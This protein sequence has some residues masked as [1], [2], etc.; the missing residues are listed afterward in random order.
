[1][2]VTYGTN[3]RDFFRESHDGDII[4]GW[5]RNNPSGDEGPYNDHDQFYLSDSHDVA[6]YAGAGNDIVEVGDGS[7]IVFGG[8]GNDIITADILGFLPGVDTLDGGAGNDRISAGAGD[9]VINGGTGDDGID[10]FG[11]ASTIDAGDGNDG[12]SIGWLTEGTVRAGSGN[13][14]IH[15][16]GRLTSTRIDGGDGDDVLGLSAVDDISAHDISEVD[17]RSV[18]TLFT[19]GARVT[20]RP[21]QFNAFHL[22]AFDFEFSSFSVVFSEG[23]S[24]DFAPRSRGGPIKASGS[25]SDDGIAS[26][27]GDDEL[28][29]LAGNDVLNARGGDD[30]LQGGAGNDILIGGAGSDDLIGGLGNDKIDYSASSAAVSITLDGW[31]ASIGGDADGDRISGVENAVGSQFDDRIG[32]DARRNVLNGG[33]GNDTLLGDEG[34]DRLVGGTGRDV[35][36]YDSGGGVTVDLS[37]GVGRYGLA[38]GD[39]FVD[40]EDLQGGQGNDRFTGNAVDNSLWGFGGDDALTGLGG[41]DALDGGDGADRLSGGAGDDV[42]IGGRGADRLSGGGG[43]DLFRYLAV[44]DSIRAAADAIVAFDA[45]EGDQIDLTAID[46]CASTSVDDAFVFIG[47]A[48][49]SGTEGELRFSGGAVQAD[50]DGD[51]VADLFVRL[52]LGV[53]LSEETFLL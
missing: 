32:G 43:A 27:D 41:A 2:S 50:V 40:V 24:V 42:L 18:E 28:Y 29:G 25:M 44:T 12:I 46:A 34:A 5:G 6:I 22:I 26:G 10:D 3:R 13:D 1:M 45:A 15:I 35:V 53:V 21:D 14:W 8:N 48:G 33:A 4:Y 17:I 49:F 37:T 52:G 7:D 11:G 19:D 20:A 16:T 47:S 36:T 23:G 38:A 51:R 30:Q 39:T 9:D 31:T